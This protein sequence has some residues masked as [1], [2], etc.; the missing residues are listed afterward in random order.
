M[1][2]SNK[3]H[4]A[5]VLDRSGSM[6]SIKADTIGGF[7]EFLKAQKAAPGKA[8]LTL[9]QFDDVSETVWDSADISGVKPLTDETYKPRGS[10]ALLDTIGKVINQ[11]GQALSGLDEAV[12]PSKVVFVI[13]TDGHENASHEF[14]L[15]NINEMIT[16]QR[17]KYAWEFVFLG[18][19]QDAILV[20]G[21]MGISQVS[22]MTFAANAKGTASAF[23]ST[24]R[25]VSDY[26]AGGRL[27]Y[28]ASDRQ[29]QT[30]AGAGRYGEYE[31]PRKAS[32]KGTKSGRA[33]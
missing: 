26:R 25:M 31:R 5:V 11:T 22:A 13:L 3:T 29:A 30:D 16:H 15:Q 33:L 6:Q 9:V 28:D 20:A 14:S 24:A 21:R 2:D 4:I 27:A 12:R 1:T 23:S 10:T 17:D 8:T 32:L 7:N 18:A 19:N